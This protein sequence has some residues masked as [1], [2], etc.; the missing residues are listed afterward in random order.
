MIIKNFLFHRVSADKDVLWPPMHPKTFERV[1]QYLTSNYTVVQLENFLEN[2]PHF[3]GSK[4][5]ATVLFDDGYKDNLD[6]AAPIL[7]KYNCPAS[8]Y[9]V[10]ECINENKPTWTYIVDHLF[11]QNESTIQ[12]VNEFVPASFHYLKWSNPAEGAFLSRK[13]KPW[14]KTLSNFQ[15]IWVLKELQNQSLSYQVPGNL[16]MNWQEVK[17]LYNAGFHIGSHSHT[18]AMLATLSSEGEIQNELQTSINVIADQLGFN[19]A[20]ISYPI[21]SWDYRVIEAAKSSGFKYGLAVE[22]RFYNTASDNLY[23]IPRVELYEEPWWKI[24]LRIN[25]VYQRVRE[26][27]K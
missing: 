21:G 11:Q 14:M 20:T 17:E 8:F 1:I 4:P 2:E 9:V 27:I 23:S 10:T 22:Q 16:M 24:K 15:R 3:R 19:P 12:L 26:L 5:I 7:K 25:G 13:V 6:V 18:H